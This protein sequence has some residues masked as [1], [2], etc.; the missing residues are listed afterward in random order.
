[1][2]LRERKGA[3]LQEPSRIKR[4]IEGFDLPAALHRDSAFSSM[5]SLDKG[6]PENIGLNFLEILTVRTQK[7]DKVEQEKT[8]L[9]KELKVN[10]E[11]K[12]GAKVKNIEKVV[13]RVHASGGTDLLYGLE[14]KGCINRMKPN[15][16]AETILKVQESVAKANLKGYDEEENEVIYKRTTHSKNVNLCIHPGP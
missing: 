8:G 4:I 14:S 10:F 11:D 16:K 12:R 2:T 3:M 7:S 5:M 6:R 1:M 15:R 9:K 13:C